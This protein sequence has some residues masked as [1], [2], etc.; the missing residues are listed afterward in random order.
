MREWRNRQTRT[1]EG[2]VSLM[3]GFKSRLSHQRE[4]SLTGI[5][6]FIVTPADQLGHPL[7]RRARTRQPH[8]VKFSGIMRIWRNWQTR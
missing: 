2:R 6:P 1:F 4:G 8:R 5:L 7:R 3:Y